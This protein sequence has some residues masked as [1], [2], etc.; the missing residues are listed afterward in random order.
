MRFA[1]HRKMPEWSCWGTASKSAVEWWNW[2]AT[3]SHPSHGSGREIAADL[4]WSCWRP[5]NSEFETSWSWKS[6]RADWSPST[7][8]RA[9]RQSPS[10]DKLAFHRSGK[11]DQDVTWIA[12]ANESANELSPCPWTPRGQWLWKNRK[13]DIRIYFR[14]EISP[15]EISRKIDVVIPDVPIWNI[16]FA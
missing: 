11:R 2:R 16:F 4:P 13:I 7:D 10:I 5:K 6:S 1:W 8:K 9:S 3:L 15:E 14:A 12:W